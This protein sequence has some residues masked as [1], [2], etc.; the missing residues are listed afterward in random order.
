MVP[1]QT[2]A[3][4]VSSIWRKYFSRVALLDRTLM[5]INAL[6]RG[7]TAELSLQYVACR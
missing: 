6:G 5:R 2:E 1:I 7:N 3:E 4:A